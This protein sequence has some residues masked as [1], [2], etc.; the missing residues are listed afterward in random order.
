[1]DSVQKAFSNETSAEQFAKS[2]NHSK[3]NVKD[4][5]IV[6]CL[7]GKRSQM[8]AET[9]VK[10]GYKKLVLNENYNFDFEFK[11]FSCFRIK[12]YKGSWSEWAEKNGLPIK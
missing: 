12:N 6:S 3:P 9:L 10:L 7:S 5:I 4:Q 1:M 11:F 8:A 2:F